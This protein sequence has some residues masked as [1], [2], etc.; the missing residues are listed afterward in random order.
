ME[1]H[2][3]DHFLIYSVLNH[4]SPK[5]LPNNI[6]SRTLKN[7]NAESF[8][9]H[10]QAQQVSW[11]ENYLITDASEK[12]DY[13]NLVFLDLLDKHAPI[14]IIKLKQCKCAFLDE[15]TRDLMI[16]RNQ[17]LKIA[18]DTKSLRDWELYR[19]SRKHVKTCLREAEMNFVQNGVQKE[20]Q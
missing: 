3:S 17:L 9:L 1:T 14:K 20:Q 13:F 19:T 8:L 18:C 4:K 12:L 10:L 16:E 5:T 15:E 11:T 2:I 6:K 7:Y